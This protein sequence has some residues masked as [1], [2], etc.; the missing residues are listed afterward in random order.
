MAARGWQEPTQH[1]EGCRLARSIGA[2]QSEDLALGNIKGGTGHGSEIAELAHEIA[3]D[4]DRL[5]PVALPMLLCDGFG[6]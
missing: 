5:V 2:E 4:N 3:H 1:A 6:Y